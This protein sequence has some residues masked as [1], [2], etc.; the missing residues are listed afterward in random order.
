MTKENAQVQ[1]SDRV[2]SGY[3]QV[4]TVPSAIKSPHSEG[5]FPKPSLSE[6]TKDQAQPDLALR[7]GGQAISA[8]YAHGSTISEMRTNI[9]PELYAKGDARL[10]WVNESDWSMHT[11]PS[12]Q[13]QQSE[14]VPAG[15]K[16]VPIEPTREMI[17]V[18]DSVLDNCKDRDY[19]STTDGSTYSYETIR[20]GTQTAIYQAM[21]EAA[22][23]PP[24]KEDQ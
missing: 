12:P 20:A 1:A 9:S 13:V 10:M 19:D 6:T 15:W 24:T 7:E 3:M 5:V 4:P 2:T 17:L 23:S 16:L 14:G 21:L 22:P 18:G 11:L 8:E